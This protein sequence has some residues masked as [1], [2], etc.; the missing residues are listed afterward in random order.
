MGTAFSAPAAGRFSTPVRGL[1]VLDSSRKII[2]PDLV[3]LCAHTYPH[4]SVFGIPPDKLIQTHGNA[5]TVSE[6]DAVANNFAAL[7]RP[8]A[9]YL[10][11]L[12]LACLVVPV[13]ASSAEPAVSTGSGCQISELR[14][15]ALLTH[16]PDERKA[17]A[18]AWL[19]KNADLC[20]IAQL[21][22]IIA[23]RPTW[24]GTA[25][26]A[27]VAQLTDGIL[28]RRSGGNTDQFSSPVLPTPRP[29]STGTPQ[30][31]AA[32]PPR[33]VMAQPPGMPGYPPQGL[34]QQ[35]GYPPQGY[36]QQPGYPP[37]GYPQQPGYPP[38]G[39]P[40]QGYPQ[41]PMIQKPALPGAAR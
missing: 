10:V 26:T 13:L 24:L 38:A 29:G 7:R 34:P 27:D 6:D 4:S 15:G 37:Q 23:N 40:P 32:P 8:A 2:I 3:N 41:Q 33:P 28:E 25:D 11:P 21:K 35:P 22:A 12:A 5:T 18:V 14:S 16:A 36:P 31:N 20:S 19:K 1:R 39:Y 30:V 9:H 17:F